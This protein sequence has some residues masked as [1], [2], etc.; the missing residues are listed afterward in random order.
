MRFNTTGLVL[1]ALG[2]LLLLDNLGLFT[3]NWHELVQFWPLILVAVG[4]SML[5]PRHNKNGSGS[6]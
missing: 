5:F 4:V 2:V 1:I 6:V 3:W